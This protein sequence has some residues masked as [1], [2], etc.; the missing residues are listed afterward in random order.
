M[1]YLDSSALVK[2]YYDEVG[3]DSLNK[4]LQVE[5]DKARPIFTS[6]LTY[7]EVHSSV[8]R[9]TR[10]KLLLPSEAAAVH[11]KFDTDWVLGFTPIALDLGVLGFIRDVFKAHPLKSADAVHLASA[12][13]LRDAAR[14]SGRFVQRGEPFIFASSDRQLT[15]AAEKYNLEIFDPETMK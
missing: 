13:W 2:R 11:D 12:L 1:L 6:V 10:E 14:L 3:S 9:R 8:A 5:T 7:A 15:T 4:R